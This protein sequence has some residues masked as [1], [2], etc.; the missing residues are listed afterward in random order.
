MSS[1]PRVRAVLHT[2]IIGLD[3]AVQLLLILGQ[4]YITFISKYDCTGFL[5]CG[6]KSNHIKYMVMVKVMA[7]QYQILEKPE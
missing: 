7:L 4:H 2:E 3:F 5:V 6:L 1:D